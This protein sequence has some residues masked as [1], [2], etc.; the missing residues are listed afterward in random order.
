MLISFQASGA[1]LDASTADRF[2]KLCP[3]KIWVLSLVATWVELGGT[4]TVGVS[5]RNLG[6]LIANWTI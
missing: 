2:W 4:N 3:L 5:S 1:D 6:S